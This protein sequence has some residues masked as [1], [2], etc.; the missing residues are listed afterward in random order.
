MPPRASP[1]RLRSSLEKDGYGLLLSAMPSEPNQSGVTIEHVGNF[2]TR[3]LP[4]TNVAEVQYSSRS[5]TLY[6]TPA[7]VD[8][9]P[10]R[11]ADCWSPPAGRNTNGRLRRRSI[12]PT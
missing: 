11:S 6:F 10:P 2:D 8:E 7:T 9:R 3:D 1:T 5:N 4:K 12:G